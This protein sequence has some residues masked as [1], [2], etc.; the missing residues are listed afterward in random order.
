MA[1]MSNIL[2]HT[3]EGIPFADTRAMAMQLVLEE[4]EAELRKIVM[5]TKLGGKYLAPKEINLNSNLQLLEFLR[6]EFPEITG[7][8]A[9]VLAEYND[10]FISAMIT[11]NKEASNLL[12]NLKQYLS[13]S[14]NG[15]LYP[16]YNLTNTGRLRANH[17]NI[18][19]IPRGDSF[20][21]LFT[22]PYHN[23]VLIWRDYSSQEPLITAALAAIDD[24][25]DTVKNGKDIYIQMAKDIFYSDTW[26]SFS[27]AEKKKARSNMKV[28][29]LGVSYGMKAKGVADASK[30][31]LMKRRPAG[32][33]LC[34]RPT[35]NHWWTF[36]RV[37][38]KKQQ[39]VK[40]S[41]HQLHTGIGIAVSMVLNIH[42]TI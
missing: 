10:P 32:Y 2:Y 14:R 39:T 16:S 35:I 19:N 20:R 17:P 8:S 28:I 27:D 33:W 5:K 3:A 9:D 42:G 18:Q 23:W 6:Q 12:G 22:A 11:M 24:W 4:K 26:D 1:T 37:K 41:I 7:T 36:M 40:L 29:I 31:L 13:N 38:W 21:Q 15:R 30:A 25:N 34:L